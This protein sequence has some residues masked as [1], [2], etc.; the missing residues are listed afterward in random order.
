MANW[1]E[2][3]VRVCL[4]S[5]RVTHCRSQ[6]PFSFLSEVLWTASLY[7][8]PRGKAP[9][10]VVILSI[11]S[12]PMLCRLIVCCS[13]IISKFCYIAKFLQLFGYQTLCLKKIIAELRIGIIQR[14]DLSASGSSPT[15]ATK[16]KGD[17]SSLPSFTAQWHYTGHKNCKPHTPQI[18]SQKE[19]QNRAI[20]FL[21][22]CKGTQIA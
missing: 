17:S 21:L 2:T 7:L 12:L 20:I 15:I 1:Q 19:S 4:H 18:S 16:Q 5:K 8:P 11:L 9:P 6:K 3:F 22:R 13:L 10:K 14:E